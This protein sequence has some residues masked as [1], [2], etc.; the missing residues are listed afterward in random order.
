[1][2]QGATDSYAKLALDSSTQRK[3]ISVRMLVCFSDN[4]NHSL[5]GQVDF[6]HCVCCD[7]VAIT[8]PFCLKGSRKLGSHHQI[9]THVISVGCWLS[10]IF[11]H[12]CKTVFPK[13]KATALF[14]YDF[15]NDCADMKRTKNT[16]TQFS[17][18]PRSQGLMVWL[19]TWS[20]LSK[21]VK[22]FPSLSSRDLSFFQEEAQP[23]HL[24]GDDGWCQQWWGGQLRA[25]NASLAACW[26]HRKVPEFT[27]TV[28]KGKNIT[29]PHFSLITSFKG[30]VSLIQME[31]KKKK[32]WKPIAKSL[33]SY[34]FL[35]LGEFLRFQY[36]PHT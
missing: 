33:L 34:C 23:G 1:M 5:C 9:S 32:A 18:P 20:L 14:C 13:K 3:R 17:S 30:P 25:S 22:S 28:L 16:Q 10:S 11:F 35:L 27:S 21:M 8:D 26:A 4:N 12:H 19:L 24:S 15:W 2:K 7:I 36:I 29:H 6:L 31:K